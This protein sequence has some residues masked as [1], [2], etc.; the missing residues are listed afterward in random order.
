MPS[1]RVK[2]ND[3]VVF[4]GRVGSLK[5]FTEDVRE[6]NTGFECGVSIDGFNSFEPGDVLEFTTQELVERGAQ[7]VAN[8][9]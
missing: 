9:G 7:A 4:E 2:R 5:R 3:H 6:V 8:K 1:V